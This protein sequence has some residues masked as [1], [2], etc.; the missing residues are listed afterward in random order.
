M[1]LSHISITNLASF[2]TFEATLPAVALIQGVNGAGK[3]SLKAV[4][5]YAFGR[6]AEGTRS[7]EH[8]PRMLLK[9]DK[10]EAT[11][12][13]DDGS[14]LRILVTP[15]S[16]T[17]MTKPKDGKRWSRTTAE[18]DNLAN[19]IGY[20][21]ILFKSFSEQKRVET[22][23]RIMPIKV[24]AEEINEAIGDLGVAYPQEPSLE[25]INA[26]YDDIYRLRTTE[27]VAADTQKKHAEELEMA[28][29]SM[30]EANGPSAAELRSE[31]EALDAGLRTF[32]DTVAR[33]FRA[34]DAEEKDKHTARAAAIDADIN[35][36]IALL[37]KERG[38]RREE[39]LGEYTHLV[40]AARAEGQ[41]AANAKRAEVLPEQERLTAAI[42]EAETHAK[43]IAQAE[44]GRQSLDIARRSEAHHREESGKM[45][46]ALD[47]LKA[48]KAVVASRLPIPG[49]TIA[50]PKSGLPVDICRE[51]GGVL[52]PFS[53]WNDTSKVLFCL[54]VAVLSH[55]ECGLV[56]V[57]SIDGVDPDTRDRLILSCQRYAKDSGLQFLLAEA[58]TGPLRVTEAV[59][60]EGVTA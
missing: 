36:R 60:A 33:T 41:A 26:Y 4:I 10:G 25:A 45:S 55:G 16:T 58:T 3:S 40:E 6:R 30:P 8:D 23:L 37:E 51:E 19:A 57:D 59:E 27:N 34:Y 38:V 53:V 9:G 54:R 52:V 46:A 1:R 28:L 17:R 39:S 21:P 7:V 42:A 5:C 35:A 29:P 12:T 43:V 11:I 22:L 14:Q 56:C 20:D 44:G 15:D 49:I 48:L 2:A 18:I 13:F 50:A 47:R 31:K 32:I 24:T